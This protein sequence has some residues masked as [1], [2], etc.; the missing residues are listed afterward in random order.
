MRM[1]Q[2]AN[3]LGDLLSR[4]GAYAASIAAIIG[5]LLKFRD[6]KKQLDADAAE[7]AKKKDTDK[8][9][10]L[11][12]IGGLRVRVDQVETGMNSKLRLIDQSLETIQNDITISQLNDLKLLYSKYMSQGY[13]TIAQREGFFALYDRYHG[14]GH[15]SLSESFR[16][17]IE[18]LPL[19]KVWK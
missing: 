16:A 1:E 17:D 18:K 14:Q 15:N 8:N 2:M 3:W 9:E 19:E 6:V 7:R 5:L 10:I 4:W 13:C 11:D 12:A